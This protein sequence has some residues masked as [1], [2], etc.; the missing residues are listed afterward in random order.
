MFLR[1]WDPNPITTNYEGDTLVIFQENAQK[2]AIWD[3]CQLAMIR[4][5]QSSPEQIL[6]HQDK[7]SRYFL[8][9]TCYEIIREI[10]DT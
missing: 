7:F 1:Y 5:Y 8:S 10:V 9:T 4:F 6:L 3:L 2:V